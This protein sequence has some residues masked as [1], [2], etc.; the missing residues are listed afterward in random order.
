MGRPKKREDGYVF[1]R[2][3]P[4]CNVEIIYNG[5][6]QYHSAE[7]EN[8]KCRKCGCGHW[9][10]KTKDTDEKL[11]KMS[12]KVSSTWKEKFNNGYSVWNTGLSKN[13]ND[14]LK[15]IS[16]KNKNYKHTDT[17]KEK[18]S[19]HSKHLW[20]SGHFNNQI[21]NNHNEFKKYQNRVHKLTKK[22][23]HLISGYD[24]TKH[25]IMGKV[26]AYQIDH[27]IDIKYG[28]DNDIPAEQ[29]AD[30]SN[31][32]FISWEENIKKGYYGKSKN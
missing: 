20:D 10:G 5:S 23:K 21:R 29:I 27:I 22:V 11:N 32:Q 9:K 4:K 18:I 13:T 1:S 25:G 3:C 15:T 30:L 24:E 31:L 26:G 7:R 12:Q 17:A 14:I 8:R 16:D 28:F 6:S 2:N 19:K